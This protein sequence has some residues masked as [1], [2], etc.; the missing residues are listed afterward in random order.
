[1][2]TTAAVAVVAAPLKALKYPSVPQPDEKD[3]TASGALP[4]FGCCCFDSG[5]NVPPRLRV[6]RKHE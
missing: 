3:K 6:Q 2:L 4:V 5:S 1:M